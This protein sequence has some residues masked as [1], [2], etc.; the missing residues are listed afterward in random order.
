MLAPYTVESG[1]PK[2]AIISSRIEAA[3]VSWIAGLEHC[4][5]ENESMTPWNWLRLA[6]RAEYFAEP[7][8]VDELAEIL[9]RAH[10][11]ELPV[12]LLGSGSNILVRDEGV[13]G[14]VVHLSAPAFCQIHPEG[15]EIVAGGGG[16]LNHVIAT[17][18]RE[19]LAGLEA[20]VGIPGSVGGAVRTNV[21]GHGAAIGQ[22]TRHVTAMT[23]TGEITHLGTSELRFGYRQSNLG[24]R[25]IIDVTFALEPG[26]SV[27]ITRQMQ[28]NWIVRRA[29]LPTGE[30]G[31]GQ[32][33]TDPMGTVAGDIIEQ[34]G[35]KGRSVGGARISEKD[36]NFVELQPGT[37]S[38]D[39]LAL[40]DQVRNEVAN[41]TGVDLETQIEVW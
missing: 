21:T 25:V 16:Y 41:T 11:Q 20:F 7:T 32:I 39:V 9:R 35:L 2:I 23:R 36:A 30:L 22:W 17:A 5:R 3:T 10:Q 40:V 38:D 34:A 14:V 24:D 6:G 1:K 31:H 13:T 29:Q 4:V 15:Q 18:A 33:F 26:D 27:A 19:G 8:S 37:S 12:R 28:K